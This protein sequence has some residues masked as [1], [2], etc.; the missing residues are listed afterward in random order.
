LTVANKAIQRKE[1]I[2]LV[3]D[4]SDLKGIWALLKIELTTVLGMTEPH[5]K[6]RD[7]DELEE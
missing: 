1:S 6:H 3:E 4:E 2:A 7:I 5:K